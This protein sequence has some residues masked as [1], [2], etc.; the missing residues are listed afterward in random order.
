MKRF[1][2]R[3]RLTVLVLILGFIIVGCGGSNEFVSTGG[4]QSGPATTAT[5][6]VVPDVSAA[7]VAPRI[8]SDATSFL[9]TVYDANGTQ[10]GQQTVT[11]G[12][13][14]VFTGIGNGLVLVRCEGL[15]SGNN[16]IG[17]FDRSIQFP[18]QNRVEIPGLIYAQTPST[19]VPATPTGNASALVFTELPDAITGGSAFVVSVTTFDADGSLVESS[20]SVDL[21]VSG[22]ATEALGTDSLINGVATFKSVSVP[23]PTDG[24][25]TLQAQQ[26]GLSASTSA[27]P[28]TP[29]QLLNPATELTE[30]FMTVFVGVFPAKQGDRD[31]RYFPTYDV[32]WDLNSSATDFFTVADG[33]GTDNFDNAYELKIGLTGGS[34][35]SF[36]AVT[37]LAYTELTWLSP[38]FGQQ[39]GLV[40]AAVNPK[41]DGF[42]DNSSETPGAYLAPGKDNRLQQLLDL[43]QAS[44]TVT[45]NWDHRYELSIQDPFSDLPGRE[46]RVVIRDSSGQS[47]LA[48]VFSETSADSND[49]ISETADLTSFVGQQVMLSFE[50][51]NLQRHSTSSAG[52]FDEF[53][54]DNV[55][56]QDGNNTEFVTNGDFETRDLTGWTQFVEP[57]SQYVRTNSRSVEGLDLVRYFYAPPNARWGRYLEQFTNPTGSDITIDVEVDIDPGSTRGWTSVEPGVLIG[58]QSSQRDDIGSVYGNGTPDPTELSNNSDVDILFTVTVPA[59]QT[60]S[61]CH[62]AYQAAM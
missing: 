30:S 27:I 21:S 1:K 38:L 41:G 48:T 60:R 3:N 61:I 62:F 17:Y 19:T 42:N 16:T 39:D 25:V 43:T 53:R 20:G 32:C 28:V 52:E 10:I 46:Y 37:N 58:P 7:A 49:D 14:A 34:L 4:S 44:G 11:R 8:S 59:G 9:I 35:D 57:V 18:G 5:L 15:D 55:S 13:D 33:G 23:F 45:L 12:A 40:A 31:D 54:V 47:I 6:T 29:G 50:M 26:N 2:R 36:D 51:L 56:V 24:N 22:A